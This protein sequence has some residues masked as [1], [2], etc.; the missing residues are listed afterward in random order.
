M[1]FGLALVGRRNN[2][3]FLPSGAIALTCR[4]QCGFGKVWNAGYWMVPSLHPEWGSDWRSE[5]FLGSQ[6]DLLPQCCR[7]C[8]LR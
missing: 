5:T 3:R 4:N 1:G 8:G 2:I 7:L 6:V